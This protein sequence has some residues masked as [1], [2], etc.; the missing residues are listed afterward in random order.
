M[1]KKSDESLFHF[2]ELD[3]H[4]AK[5]GN[6]ETP[7]AVLR[8]LNKLDIPSINVQRVEDQL[9]AQ[10]LTFKT[11]LGLCS[12]SSERTANT[13]SGTH[14][15]CEGGNRTSDSLEGFALRHLLPRIH[16]GQV[17]PDEL[18]LLSNGRIRSSSSS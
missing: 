8:V 6:P 2:R 5:S 18:G 13:V 17:Q 3:E 12:P 1:H 11:G 14:D 4:I 10:S 16:L 7:T 15:E 9:V